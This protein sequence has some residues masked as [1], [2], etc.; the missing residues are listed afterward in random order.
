[1]TVRH[2]LISGASSG[3]GRALALAYAQQGIRLALIGR[4]EQRLADVA[5][6]AAAQGAETVP[7]RLDVRDRAA[8]REWVTRTDSTHPFDL[9]IANAGITTG[10]GPNGIAEDPEAVRSI[11]ATN[12]FGVLNVVEPLL[13]P[14]AARRSGHIAIIGS[15]AGLLSLPYAPAYCAT[16]AAVHAYARAL[17]GRLEPQGVRVSLVI[18]GFVK[19]PLNDSITA[20]KPFELSD[21]AAASIIKRGL[22]RGAATIGFPWPLMLA[23]RFAGLLPARLVDHVMGRFE[24]NVPETVERVQGSIKELG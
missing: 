1:M 2:I 9:V 19:T 16:K 23:A 12:L 11:F 5:K 10:L 14:M 15:I 7:V 21:V 17:R 3:I 8:M 20:F 22:A 6:A 4:D 18:P 13:L 24:V